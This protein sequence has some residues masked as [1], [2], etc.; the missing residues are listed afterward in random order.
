MQ[1]EE[2]RESSSDRLASSQ[3]KRV[4]RTYQYEEGEGKVLENQN[5]NLNSRSRI[6]KPDTRVIGPNS[7]Q[8][9]SDDIMEIPELTVN[10][11]YQEVLLQV[12]P[13]PKTTAMRLPTF[14]ELV[15]SG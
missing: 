1:N 11:D 3:R 15:R 8:P 5:T 14:E 12:P 4:P 7:Q 9:E 13:A 10:D 6:I 2:S